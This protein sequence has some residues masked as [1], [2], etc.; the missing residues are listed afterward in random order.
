MFQV[1]IKII[2]GNWITRNVRYLFGIEH[3]P[4]WCGKDGFTR[5]DNPFGPAF[6]VVEGTI[7]VKEGDLS[8]I[9]IDTV[10]LTNGQ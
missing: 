4:S 3:C 9:K 10:A 2:P 5:P 1:K 6:R 7:E 8:A